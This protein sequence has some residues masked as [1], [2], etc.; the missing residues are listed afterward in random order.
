M[1]E[2]LKNIIT[3]AN[4]WYNNKLTMQFKIIVDIKA[5]AFVEKALDKAKFT[6]TISKGIDR[7]EFTLHRI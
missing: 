2:Y 1:N 7:T 4:E 6:F 5:S 3:N